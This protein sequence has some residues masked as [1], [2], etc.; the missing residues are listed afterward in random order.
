[1]K[2]LTANNFP[3]YPFLQAFASFFTALKDYADLT[4]TGHP[5]QDNIHSMQT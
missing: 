5:R 4:Q 3:N 1:M 2:K